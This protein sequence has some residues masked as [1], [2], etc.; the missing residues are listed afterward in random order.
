MAAFVIDQAAFSGSDE[1]EPEE[2]EGDID[3]LIDD[4]SDCK[5][6][7]HTQY[8]QE[9]ADEHEQEMRKYNIQRAA[10]NKIETEKREEREALEKK[11]REDVEKRKR[12]IRKGNCIESSDDEM[13]AADQQPP[14]QW[15]DGMQDPVLEQQADQQPQHQWT[16]GMQDP[17]LAQAPD[18]QPPHQLDEEMP[19]PVL[20]QEGDKEESQSDEELGSE[21][22]GDESEPNDMDIDMARI[23]EPQ[24]VCHAPLCDRMC[25]PCRLQMCLTWDKKYLKCTVKQLDFVRLAPD[26]CGFLVGQDLPSNVT[27]GSCVLI[28]AYLHEEEEDARVEIPWE[29]LINNPPW[30]SD[31]Q[32]MIDFAIEKAVQDNAKAD[33]MTF[34]RYHVQH[35][36]ELQSYAAVGEKR[37]LCIATIADAIQRLF[38]EQ[39]SL[40]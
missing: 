39:L 18:Q 8:L 3:D 15:T 24:N 21:S 17:V 23:S 37:K 9:Q 34:I 30:L 13:Q 28:A 36:H 4:A 2:D 19:D 31:A 7:A 11:K 6:D 20:E 40:S 10:L 29:V 5:Q 1:E 12:R 33:M 26:S 14:H 32:K 27:C 25:A 16:D 22:S 35:Q 38:K